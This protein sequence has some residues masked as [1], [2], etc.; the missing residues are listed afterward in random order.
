MLPPI[1]TWPF[2]VAANCRLTAALWSPNT[3]NPFG[4]EASR[5]T[6]PVGKNTP[7]NSPAPIGSG[8]LRANS[9]V[10]FSATAPTTDWECM[11]VNTPAAPCVNTMTL[12]SS[13]PVDV[14]AANLRLIKSPV[15][16][17]E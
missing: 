8:G 11:A 5:A 7:M 9:T 17:A 3:K 16:S 10:V 1:W 12:I 15:K 6:R 4:P 14:G 13:A 2:D